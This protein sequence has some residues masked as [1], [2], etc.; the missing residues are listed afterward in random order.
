MAEAQAE[1][2]R[3]M[4]VLED[5]SHDDEHMRCRVTLS[6]GQSYMRSK[7]LDKAER[8]LKEGIGEQTTVTHNAGTHR[9]LPRPVQLLVPCRCSNRLTVG[10]HPADI[11]KALGPKAGTL[12]EQ[13]ERQMG[14]LLMNQCARPSF[15]LT[16]AAYC[17]ALKPAGSGPIW[18]TVLILTCLPMLAK[19]VTLSECPR[20][21]LCLLRLSSGRPEWP[22]PTR[23]CGTA[24]STSRPG[25]GPHNMDYIPTTWP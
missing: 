19:R 21:P 12:L 23:S 14:Q 16:P 20:R 1:F 22:R 24:S 6:R 13:V 10:C 7:E 3:A 25:A 9:T 17:S 2:E 4:E 15:I 11:A 18:H 8:M 5:E